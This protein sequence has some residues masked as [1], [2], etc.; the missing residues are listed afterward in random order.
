M[1]TALPMGRAALPAPVTVLPATLACRSGTKRCA[2]N[3]TNLN[4]LNSRVKG[5]W[6]RI[7][8]WLDSGVRRKDDA[9]LTAVQTEQVW[10]T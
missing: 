1:A 4:V 9:K 5:D 3:P 2:T 7:Y 10:L 6:L 8:A